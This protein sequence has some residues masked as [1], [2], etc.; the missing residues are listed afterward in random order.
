MML[1]PLVSIVIPIY[2]RA[3][4]LHYCINSVLSQ[5]YVNW[6]LLLVD[7]GSTDR[8]SEICK[9]YTEKDERIR[10]FYQENKGAGPARNYGLKEAKGAWITFVDSDDAIMSNH[11][12][13]IV[14]ELCG[15]YD[16][17]MVNHCKATYEEGKLR[18]AN[19]YWSNIPSQ[20]V[21]G[22]KDVMLFL[23]KTLNPYK[24][25]NYCCWDKFFRKETIEKYDVLFPE[26]VPTG[27]DMMFVNDFLKYVDRFY[28]SSVGTYVPTPMGNEGIEHLALIMRKPEEYFYC[29]CRNYD[30]LMQLYKTT[31]VEV[32]RRYAAHY[33][34]CDTFVRC[35][36]RYTH[37]RTRRILGKDAVMGFMQSSLKNFLEQVREDIE[38]VKEPVY[39]KQCYKILDGKPSKVYDHWFYK[40][41]LNDL[42]YAIKRR[43]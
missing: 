3:N 42:Y 2:N 8:S 12:S 16:L 36:V 20:E 41:L 43:F 4:T 21:C 34:V 23:Y 7:D 37:W 25:Y 28:Y 13:Q 39:K 27:Q 17:I 10:Y 38:Y 30:M 5:D 31:G 15:S 26:D 9:E 1:N 24:Y 32:V 33:V 6:E 22:K 18:K 11:L 40:N 35:I 14:F 19:D 29:H